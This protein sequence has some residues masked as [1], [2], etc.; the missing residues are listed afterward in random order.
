MSTRSNGS[1]GKTFSRLVIMISTM[2]SWSK[3]SLLCSTSRC[4]R[5]DVDFNLLSAICH[6]LWRNEFRA[7][8]RSRNS[9]RVS[10]KELFY[11][12]VWGVVAVAIYFVWQ[13]FGFSNSH[14]KPWHETE[15]SQ[16]LNDH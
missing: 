13:Y 12:A 10:A 3:K 4:T 6:L 5:D 8:A 14:L 2:I 9:G 7:M 16:S 11:L 1:L 15:P